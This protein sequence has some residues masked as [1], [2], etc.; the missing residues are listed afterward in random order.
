MSKR[1]PKRSSVWVVEYAKRIWMSMFPCA[2]MVRFFGWGHCVHPPTEKV[3]SSRHYR[4]A[5]YDREG[6]QANDSPAKRT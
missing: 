2:R 3:K 6:A 5:R 4:A 1:K